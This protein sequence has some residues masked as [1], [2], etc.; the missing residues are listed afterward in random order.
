LKRNFISLRK[1]E[2]TIPSL[3]KKAS[4]PK[5]SRENYGASFRKKQIIHLLTFL[6]KR[7]TKEEKDII[8]THGIV[9]RDSVRGEEYLLTER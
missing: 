3:C 7:S 9:Q 2:V 5:R 6:I 8:F 4:R 1:G